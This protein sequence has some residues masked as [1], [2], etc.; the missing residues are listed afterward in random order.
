MRSRLRPSLAATL[1]VIAIGASGCGGKSTVKTSTLTRT[2]AVRSAPAYR[3]G[4]YCLPSKEARY[5]AAG[6]ACKRHHLAR[7]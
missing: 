1:L 4:Q 5:R 3:A 6:F 2:Q 7:S